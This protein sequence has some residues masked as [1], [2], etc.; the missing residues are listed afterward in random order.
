VYIEDRDSDINLLLKMFD[1]TPTF[2]IK[3][4]TGDIMKHA[5]LIKYE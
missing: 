3:I 2:G 1:Q 4:T 5:T